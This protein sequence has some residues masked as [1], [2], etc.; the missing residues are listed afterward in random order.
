[1]IFGAVFSSSVV[2]AERDNELLWTDPDEVGSLE[3][4]LKNSVWASGEDPVECL[5]HICGRM[6][7]K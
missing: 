6:W 1:M 5:S 4:V 7:L 3:I 2:L